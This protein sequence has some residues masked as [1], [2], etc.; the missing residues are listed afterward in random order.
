VGD[1][2]FFVVITSSDGIGADTMR[3]ECMALITK[4]HAYAN[5]WMELQ[6][7]Q[8]CANDGLKY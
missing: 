8:T 1:N 4:H 6:M 7:H 3:G 2:F 5:V